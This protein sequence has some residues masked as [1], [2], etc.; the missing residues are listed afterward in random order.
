MG[1]FA[2]RSVLDVIEGFHLT[3]AIAALHEA[4]VLDA[5]K[6]PSGV[7][8]VAAERG[9]DTAMLRTVL[10]YVACR[11]DLLVREGARY[12]TTGQYGTEVR[13][14]LD[15]Y[16]GA[17]GPCALQISSVLRDP[18]AG[19]AAVNRERHASAFADLDRTGFAALPDVILQL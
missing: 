16:V 6:R 14:I 13:F 11:T 17:Y 4:G 18:A 10:E 3:Q 7:H 8:E 12:R 2:R 5:L 19:L 9:W 1:R 15:Q